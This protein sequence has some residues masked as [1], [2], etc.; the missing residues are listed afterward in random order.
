MDICGC[1]LVGME[2]TCP[3][4]CVCVC[5]LKEFKARGVKKDSVPDVIKVELTYVP[6][7]GG[8]IYSDVNRFFYSPGQAL[9]PSTTWVVLLSGKLV[10]RNISH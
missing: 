1:P 9:V 8:I 2:W 6:I 5:P 10:F 3:P 7:K 4:L